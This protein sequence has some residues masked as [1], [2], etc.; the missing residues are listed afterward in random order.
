MVLDVME[1]NSDREEKL[2]LKK[3]IKSLQVT[4]R[5]K[6]YVSYFEE[7]ILSILNLQIYINFP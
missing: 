2:W 4:I 5:V 3:E 1:N 7:P 6:K